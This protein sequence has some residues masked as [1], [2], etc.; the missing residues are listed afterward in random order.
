MLLL[1]HSEKAIKKM[2]KIAF[3]IYLKINMIYQ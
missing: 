2:H 3:L 1:Y